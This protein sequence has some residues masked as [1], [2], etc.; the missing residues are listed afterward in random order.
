M[1]FMEY[2]LPRFFGWPELFN[3]DA[4]S[5]MDTPFPALAKWYTELRKVNAFASVHQ[6]VW[7]YWEKME[8]AGQFAP[9]VEGIAANTDPSIK[10]TYEVPQR[11]LL[12]YQEPPPPGK[13]TGRYINQPDK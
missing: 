1:G 6:D 4:T 3:P 8:A 9:I 10:V 7:S 12:N 13:T 5:L 11:V 2:M